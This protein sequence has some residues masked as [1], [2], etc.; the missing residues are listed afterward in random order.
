VPSAQN[1]I[2]E[3]SI[4][5][6]PFVNMSSDKDQEYF[7]DGLTE[8]LIDMLTKVSGL[9]VPAR[10]SSF[11]FKGKSED[12][13]TIAR[14]LRVA[15]VLEGS[16]RKSGDTLRVTAQL[17]R[18]DNGYH[19]WSESYDRKL[20]DVFKVQD[21]IAGAVVTALKFHLLP[22]QP[23]AQEELR[24]SNIE[25][26]THYLEGRQSFNRGD[27]EGYQRAV[28]AFTAAT[29]LDPHYAV[30]YAALALAQFWVAD[31]ISDRAGNEAALKSAL[32][33]AEKAVTL[34]PKLA[35]GYA[36]RGF[37]RATVGFDFKGG[38]ADLDKAVA[39]SP[40]DADVLHR[41]AVVLAVLGSLPAAI[42][43][44]T[45]ALELDPLSAEICM[46]LGFFFAA[47]QQL[48]EARPMYERALAI[49]PTSIRAL[50]NL[51]SLDLLENRPEE[52]LAAF[53]Q[54]GSE[55]F[56]LVGQAMAEYSLGHLDASQRILEQLIAKDV[57]YNVAEIYAW[58]D[59]ND[60]A[61]R[62]L[63]LSLVKQEPTLTWIKIDPFF[64]SLR[65]D[66]RYKALLRKMNLPE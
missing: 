53:R 52:A 63:E 25:A 57:S 66:A 31:D 10:T 62:W 30:A 61:F 41:S 24:T 49:A 14:R 40:H 28:T 58:R 33:A 50:Y 23:A 32:A 54:N 65:G 60:H 34:D 42:S 47:N 56:R 27:L 37:Q 43:R 51:G 13:A 48:A 64:R 46:R 36:A 20:T 22:T 7:S 55:G 21:E 4:A 19:L 26:F 5:V 12:I 44:E 3:K 18:A 1:V 11:Y 15:N 17:I 59:E 29:T 45:E 8:E 16:V 39:L 35:A 6:L 9:R 2:S 38:K